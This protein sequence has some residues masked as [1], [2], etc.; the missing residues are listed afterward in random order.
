LF[1]RRLQLQEYLRSIVKIENVVETSFILRQFLEINPSS[2][3]LRTKS[4]TASI[5][6]RN[7]SILHLPGMVERQSEEEES[8]E[9][10]RVSFFGPTEYISIESSNLTGGVG[11]GE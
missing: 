2:P 5:D 3:S 6:S 1:K 7:A 4:T 10:G 11:A 9:G 8:V